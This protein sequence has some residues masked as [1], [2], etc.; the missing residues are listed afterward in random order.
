MRVETV[1][2]LYNDN[3]VK[4]N[5]GDFVVITT[6]KGNHYEGVIKRI[7]PKSLGVVGGKSAQILYKDIE[8]IL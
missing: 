3:G 2:N 6:T 7:Y 5:I 8:S 4:L 1:I